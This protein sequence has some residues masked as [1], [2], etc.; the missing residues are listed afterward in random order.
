MLPGFTA[1]VSTKEIESR[2]TYDVSSKK[3]S[4]NGTSSARVLPLQATCPLEADI[5]VYWNKPPLPNEGCKWRTGYGQNWCEC[6]G[7]HWTYKGEMTQKDCNHIGS[8]FLMS[9]ATSPIKAQ[10]W[11]KTRVNCPDSACSGP[12]PHPRSCPTGQCQL[13]GRCVGNGQDKACGPTCQDCT[14][15]P[16]CGGTCVS[17]GS[18]HRCF[19][20]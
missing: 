12:N 5:S 15:Y 7:T 16:G 2:H 8:G 1:F 19:C 4:S 13:A 20:P 17:S 9:E 6:W 14:A 3:Y 18:G 10:C 11:I